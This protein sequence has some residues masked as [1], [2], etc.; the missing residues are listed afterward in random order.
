MR[1]HQ[2][3]ATFLPGLSTPANPNGK[4]VSTRRPSRAGLVRSS[5]PRIHHDIAVEL[6][7]VLPR[8][9]GGL[10]PTAVRRALRRARSPVLRSPS[11]KQLSEPRQPSRGLPPRFFLKA[12]GG[13]PEP[14]ADGGAWPIGA[15][16]MN[17]APAPATLSK[18]ISVS[19]LLSTPPCDE[20]AP[21]RPIAEEA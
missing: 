7:L 2:P 14:I 6:E 21:L 3:H 12:G 13:V 20:Q 11:S 10:F 1:Q 15:H 8:K 4:E 9:P 18:A 16:H 5:S 19:R 17:M